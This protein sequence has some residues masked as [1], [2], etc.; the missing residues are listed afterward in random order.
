[1]QSLSPVAAAQFKR[2]PYKCRAKSSAGLNRAVIEAA[3]APPATIIPP[4]EPAV[5][6]GSSHEPSSNESELERM[7]AI[8][9]PSAPTAFSARISPQLPSHGA[10]AAVLLSHCRL[11]TVKPETRSGG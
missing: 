9:T 4:T 10:R 3:T 6:I 1:M 2:D 8:K 7:T 11:K 5:V